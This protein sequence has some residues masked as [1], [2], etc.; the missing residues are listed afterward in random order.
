MYHLS[1][2]ERMKCYTRKCYSSEVT[3]RFCESR[4]HAV[5]FHVKKKFQVRSD[6]AVLVI[7]LIRS[8]CW[9]YKKIF[10]RWNGISFSTRFGISHVLFMCRHVG[11]FKLTLNQVTPSLNTLNK[12]LQ[13]RTWFCFCQICRFLNETSL[14]N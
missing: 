8:K 11:R 10:W 3:G 5:T 9:K 6:K 7:L 13:K 4:K 2:R 14:H 1:E 12:S